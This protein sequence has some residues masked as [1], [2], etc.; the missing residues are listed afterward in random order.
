MKESKFIELLN[1]YID[2]EISREESQLLE[3]EIAANPDRRKIYLQYCRMHRA[4]VM[5][6]DSFKTEKTPSVSKLA[7]AA[8]KVDDKIAL[9]PDQTP[10]PRLRWA[11]A[12]GGLA[13]AAACV[14]FMV[15][16]RH[17]SMPS[18]GLQP[19]DVTAALAPATMNEFVAS[20]TPERTRSSS[21]FMREVQPD[22]LQRQATFVGL[23][24]VDQVKLPPLR[25]IPVDATVFERKSS[26]RQ[27]PRSFQGSR[28]VN[29]KV[30][31]TAFQ[32]QK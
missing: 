1:L 14:T 22:A 11:F 4:S 31:T 30:E 28:P 23:D 8:R 13:V 25:V 7:T 26:L 16:K 24:W 5:L 10:S 27:D 20:I 17:S 2:Q 18:T 32:F 9:F 6:V 12:V 15:V 21:L 29:G 19:S 3:A